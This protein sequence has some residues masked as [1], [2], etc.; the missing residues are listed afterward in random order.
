LLGHRVR[1]DGGHTRDHFVTEQLGKV[2]KLTP[3][4]PELEAG[5]GVPRVAI[6]LRRVDG[7]QRLVSRDGSHDYTDR[8]AAVA[9]RRTRELEH[10][11]S[12]FIFKNKSPTCGIERVPVANANGVKQD[13]SGTGLFVQHFT[14]LAP[15]V[16]IE[17]QGRLNDPVLRENFIE[18]VYAFTRWQKLSPDDVAG[19]IEFHARHKLMLMARGS[20]CYTRLGR[21]VAGVT[22]V[23]LSER[24][25][26][27]IQEFMSTMR[28][29]ANRKRHYNVLQHVMGYF[30]RKL[31]SEDK[32]ELLALLDAYRNMQVPLA[33]PLALMN[34]YLRKYP[35]GYLSRQHYLDP[36]SEALGLR[37]YI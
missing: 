15:L 22:R 5:M 21:I 3:V 7:K 29:R 2:F 30:K 31:D 1:Y 32:Q 27:Y 19:F 16:P 37:A 12:G 9:R 28:E 36:Y 13:R 34:H 26:R 33:T 17:E 11:I 18:R 6:H 25:E 23:D 24:R 35:D 10:R 8:I 14:R 20:E 4:C